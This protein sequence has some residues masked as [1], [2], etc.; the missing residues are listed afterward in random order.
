MDADKFVPKQTRKRYIGINRCK[1]SNKNHDIDDECCGID[2]ESRDI[3]N[4]SRDI[5][6]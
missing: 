2:N 5:A 6:Y 4:E 1:V 3:H